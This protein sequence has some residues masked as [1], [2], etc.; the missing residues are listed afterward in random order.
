MAL[1]AFLDCNDDRL[2]GI[3]VADVPLAGPAD[4][5]QATVRVGNCGEPCEAASASKDVQVG[6]GPR[7]GIQP[8]LV[9]AISY[10][11]GI[12]HP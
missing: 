9:E 5:A 10:R 1:F 3:G 8:V 2:L 11:V 6:Q 4:T 7:W 12:G